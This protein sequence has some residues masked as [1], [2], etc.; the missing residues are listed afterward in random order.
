MQPRKSTPL[1]ILSFLFSLIATTLTQGSLAQ[2]LPAHS[3]NRLHPQAKT[4]SPLADPFDAHFIDAMIPHHQGA[5][6]MAQQAL[7]EA[8][9]PELT[10]LAE[11]IIQSQQ[12]EIDQ[13]QVWHTRWSH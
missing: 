4:H 11:S 8:E 12:A 2:A 10:T 13:M 3:E 1:A 6:A 7:A 5:I 9:H